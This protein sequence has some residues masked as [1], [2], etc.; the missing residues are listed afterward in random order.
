MADDEFGRTAPNIHDQALV[1]R[2]RQAV[3]YADVDEPRLFAAGNYFNR[4]AQNCF[5]FLYKRARVLG[6]AQGIGTDD[7]HGIVRQA[8]QALG[9]QAKCRKGAL[10][11]RGFNRF[12][13]SNTSTEADGFFQCIK[14]V[15]LAIDNTANLQV[16][17]V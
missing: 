15:Q 16:K 12:I 6:H 3:C 4:I 9:E 5:G 11:G 10:G 7:A 17:A 14:W 1:V 13:G 2:W 8:A